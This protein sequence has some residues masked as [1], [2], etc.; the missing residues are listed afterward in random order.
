MTSG[1]LGDQPCLRLVG[2]PG[3]SRPGVHAVVAHP[4][5]PHARLLLFYC[6]SGVEYTI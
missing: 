2:G 3:P 5:D 6:C 4:G 1:L